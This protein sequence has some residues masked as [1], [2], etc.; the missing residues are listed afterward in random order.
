LGRQSGFAGL[1]GRP[2]I[3]RGSRGTARR[4]AMRAPICSKPGGGGRDF[5]RGGPGDTPGQ[6]RVCKRAIPLGV[7]TR[8]PPGQPFNTRGGIGDDFRTPREFSGGPNICPPP[9]GRRGGGKKT[10]LVPTPGRIRAPSGRWV[11]LVGGA[12]TGLPVRHRLGRHHGNG[13]RPGGPVHHRHFRETFPLHG[14]GIVLPLLRGDGRLFLLVGPD[15]GGVGRP[16]GRGEH[17]PTGKTHG[18]PGLSGNSRP[19]RARAGAPAGR[20]TRVWGGRW[21]RNQTLGPGGTFQRRV[22]GQA[23]KGTLVS[24]TSRG[25]HGGTGDKRIGGRLA[26]EAPTLAPGWRS[27]WR[28]SR[29]LGAGE[30]PV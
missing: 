26:I 12:G 25:F 29:L 18:A 23:F 28:K 2:W 6:N 24:P 14:R 11:A 10:L 20:G 13:A 5:F 30:K 4:G 27:I 9:P 7:G 19:P 3:R 15:A 16:T 22:F 8:H 17:F 21:G 1:L